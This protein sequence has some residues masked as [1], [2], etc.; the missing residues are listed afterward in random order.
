[1]LN[2]P[3]HKTP[4]VSVVM[5]MY[6]AEKYVHDAVASVLNQTYKN[7]DFI[8]INNGSTDASLNIVQAFNDARIFVHT[9]TQ[10][11]PLA[12]AWNTGIVLAKGEFIARMDA[13]DICLPNRLS[14]QV[15]YMLANTDVGIL[16]TQ[17]IAIGNKTRALPVTHNQIVWHMLNACPMLHP[18][19]MFRK[20][21]LDNH[22]LMYDEQFFGAEDYELWMR[23]CRVTTMH[24]LPQALVKYRYHNSTHQQM[25]PVVAQQNTQIKLAHIQWLMPSLSDEQ[26]Q[27]LA[28]YFNRHITHNRSVDWYTQLI[29]LFNDVLLVYPQ[30]HQHLTVEFNKCLWFHLSSEPIWYNK[31]QKVLTKTP[32]FYIDFKQK[33]WLKIKPLL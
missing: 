12:N 10:T 1:V 30:Y 2:Q 22:K 25:L 29:Q 19:V 17:L 31:V 26:K 15:E 5:S 18:S 4:L 8:I 14:K 7:F 16:G 13:D 3:K 32:W 21:V 24:N 6:N 9:N 20:Q 23:A 28:L 11:Q 27:Q 33:V